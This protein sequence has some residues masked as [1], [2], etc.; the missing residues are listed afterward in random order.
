MFTRIA[1]DYDL[2]NRL[3]TFGQDEVWRKAVIRRAKLPPGGAYLL[4]LG[5]GTGD[6]GFEAIRQNPKVVSIEA[7]F[8]FEMLRVG[9]GR[10][11]QRLPVHLFNQSCIFWSAADA[12][13]L[14]FPDHTFDAVV[15]GFLM[16]NVNDVSLALREQHRVLKPSGRIVILDTTRPRQNVFSPLIRFHMHRIIPLLGRLISGQEDAYEYLPDSSEVFLSAE[17]LA[18]RMVDAGFQ[19]IAFSRLNFD[20]VAIH[21]G[22]K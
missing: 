7:D 16:R 22:V 1:S 2:M 21:W 14:P 3:M 13:S 19:Q 8:T 9:R 10:V 12:L 18:A 20:T 11:D 4:D 17:V 15:S 6:L 5:G